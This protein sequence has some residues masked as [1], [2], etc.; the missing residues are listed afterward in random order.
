MQIYFL[1]RNNGDKEHFATT[2]ILNENT[3]YKPYFS[4]ESFRYTYL[5]LI[6][7]GTYMK[8]KSRTLPMYLFGSTIGS[9]RHPLFQLEDGS[10]HPLPRPFR[11]CKPKMLEFTFYNSLW[12]IAFVKDVEM[13]VLQYIIFEYPNRKK[14]MKVLQLI[15]LSKKII[16]QCLRIKDSFFTQM[17]MVGRLEKKVDELGVH[18]DKYDVITALVHFGNV[19]Y[20][21]TTD[22]FNGNKKL[23]GEVVKSV[24]F[25]HGRVQ[26]G[27]FNE[28]PHG[29]SEWDGERGIFNFN[30][31]LN[32]LKHFM[33][34][35]DRFYEKYRQSGYLQKLIK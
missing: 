16:P 5:K 13:I 28:I 27:F 33:T 34:Y 7:S 25:K 9:A 17:A 2:S 1:L 23:H 32:V 8:T 14:A 30:L 20:G 24:S 15:C 10:S 6:K 19:Q 31:K 3:V 21:G 35:G 4:K 18:I 12:F 29:A 11:T 26:V 22:Y